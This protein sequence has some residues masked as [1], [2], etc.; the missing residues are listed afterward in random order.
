MDKKARKERILGSCDK[1][2]WKLIMI[3]DWWVRKE[4]ILDSCD[5]EESKL[6]MISDWWVRKEKLC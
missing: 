3:S 6:I 5:K 2:E 4:I 1:E